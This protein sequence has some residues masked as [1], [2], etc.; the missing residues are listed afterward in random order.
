M[1]EGC[2]SQHGIS[3]FDYFAG[4]AVIGV[5]DNL[6]T[7]TFTKDVEHYERIARRSYQIAYA[8]IVEKRRLGDN[9]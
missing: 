7:G 3:L 8:M 5:I 2:D 9:L 4:Q 1:N 6:S